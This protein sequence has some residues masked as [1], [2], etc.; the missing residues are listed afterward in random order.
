VLTSEGPYLEEWTL[1]PCSRPALLGWAC[2]PG[3]S[4]VISGPEVAHLS[5]GVGIQPH[6]PKFTA[7]GQTVAP[8]LLLCSIFGVVQVGSRGPVLI[9]LQSHERSLSS[10]FTDSECQETS[11][12]PI[13]AKAKATSVFPTKAPTK[14]PTRVP[15]KV[16][17]TVPRKT[18]MEWLITYPLKAFG[19]S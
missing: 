12:T 17:T 18:V 14:D 4:P 7:I 9:L 10:L 3:T 5:V 13:F 2:H 1:R 16:P 19:E 11:P 8:S 6:A 15:T